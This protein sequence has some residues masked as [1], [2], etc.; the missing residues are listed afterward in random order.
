[1]W[2][3]EAIL[4]FSHYLAFIFIFQAE[5]NV[6]IKY[7]LFTF[8]VKKRFVFFFV[9]FFPPAE[10]YGGAILSRGKQPGKLSP[11]RRSPAAAGAGNPNMD[12]NIARYCT[13]NLTD[14]LC[15]IDITRAV[16]AWNAHRIPGELHKNKQ[17]E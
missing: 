10:S 6:N 9:L 14:K 5:L 3:Y 17:E 16:L 12:N 13:S 8:Y 15:K 11:A 2:E 7:I 1:M 4:C